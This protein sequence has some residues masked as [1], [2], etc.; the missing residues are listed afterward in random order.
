MTT[1]APLA[2]VIGTYAHT[3]A[4]AS[5]FLPP[6]VREGV[7]VLYTFCRVVDDLADELPPEIG[8][9]AL[10]AWCDWLRAVDQGALPNGPGPMPPARAYI[11]SVTMTDALAE[12]IVRFAIPVRYFVELV[13]GVRLDA[14]RSRVQTTDGLHAFCYAAAGTVGRMMCHVLGTTTAEATDRAERL[15]IAMQLTNILRDVGE[16]WYRGRLY[17]PGRRTRTPQWG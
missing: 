3:F 15:G 13:E 16:D 4:F 5:R 1:T 14:T 10:D 8:V 12:V 17:L 9:P 7:A 11:D 2:T 6:V